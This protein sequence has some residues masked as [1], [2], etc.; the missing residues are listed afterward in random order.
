MKH[1]VLIFG[2]V[3]TSTFAQNKPL[4]F[5]FNEVPQS[6][7]INPSTNLDNGFYVGIPLLSHIHAN[8]GSTGFNTFDLF[9]D[10]ERDFNTKLRDV[11][12][13]LNERDFVTFNQQLDIFSAGFAYGR[14]FDK[15]N[16]LSFGLYQETDIIA[17]FPKDYAILAYEGNATNLGRNFDLSDASFRGEVLSVFHI[18]TT[19]KINKKITVGAR[20]KIYSSIANVTSINNSGSF[21]TLEGDNN[22]LTH[23]FDLDLGVHTSG[24]QS[25][26]DDDNSDVSNDIKTLRKRL[27]FGG[28]LGLGFD[29]GFTYTPTDQLTVE[30]SLQ[31]VGFI[32]HTKDVENYNVEGTYTFEGVNPLFPEIANGQTAEDYWSQIAD[33]FDTLFETDTTDTK[34]TTLRPLK[35]NA[36]LRYGF[37]KQQGKDCNCVKDDVGY[38]NEIGA[39]LFVIKRPRG[40]QTALTA[41]YYRRLFKALRAK[42]TYTA[43]SYSFTNVGFGISSHINAFNI[44]IFADNL[45]EYQNLAKANSASFQLGFNLIFDKKWK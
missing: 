23:H 22:L 35:L 7:L 39:Q 42:V 43:D 14:G 31:D 6:V 5:G 40:P 41:Y 3:F 36:A 33:D 44:Y 38:I 25:L 8:V 15:D 45:L 17:Y 12:Y 19:K 11:V 37:G 9:A 30:G 10:D 4:L 13:S 29:L 34:Y 16:Y 1:L 28:N 26:I 20:F 18:G 2:F 32:S 24:I 27:L 21:V